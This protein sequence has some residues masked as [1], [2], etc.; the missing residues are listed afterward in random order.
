MGF[1]CSVCDCLQLPGKLLFFPLADLFRVGSSQHN[2]CIAILVIQGLAVEPLPVLANEALMPQ[3]LVLQTPEVPVDGY[4]LQ[5]LLCALH[6]T[7]KVTRIH[8]RP[9]C[10]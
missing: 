1:T 4:Q 6:P 10:Y 2:G 8:V 3:L 5:G 9:L 7:R